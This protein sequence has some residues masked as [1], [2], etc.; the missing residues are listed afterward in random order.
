MQAALFIIICQDI[1]RFSPDPLHHTRSRFHPAIIPGI[2][3]AF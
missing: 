1:G 2:R 3:K